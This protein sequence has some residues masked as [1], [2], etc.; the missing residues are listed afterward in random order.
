MCI[1]VLILL[2]SLIVVRKIEFKLL[3]L[4]EVATQQGFRAFMRALFECFY[5]HKIA[6]YCEKDLKS[7]VNSVESGEK[8]HVSFF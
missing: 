8:F 2:W 6:V 4:Y 3:E 1:A 5:F 7:F